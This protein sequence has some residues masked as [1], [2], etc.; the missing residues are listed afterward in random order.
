MT[1]M[2]SIFLAA[3]GLLM[4]VGLT[5]QTLDDAIRLSTL[6]HIGTA[7]FMG[8]GGAMTALG[9]DYSASAYNPAG[10]GLIRRSELTFTPL[11][12]TNNTD[13]RWAANR[14]NDRFS[15]LQFSNFGLVISGQPRNSGTFTN[16]SF[17]VGYNRLA[18]FHSHIFSSTR[19]EG[20]ILDRFTELGRGL[21]P[22]RIDDFEVGPAYDVFALIFDPTDNTYSSDLEAGTALRKEHTFRTE[23]SI[24]EIY[25]SFAG[26]L[27][28]K[29]IMGLTL[30][31]PIVNI[32]ED[33]IYFEE[34]D[35]GVNP[36]F[37]SFEFTEN[38]ELSGV[39][40]QL[41]AGMIYRHSQALRFG[42]AIHSPTWYSM[43]SEFT[44][45]ATYDY[46]V[47]QI[48]E[49]IPPGPQTANSPRGLFDYN[50]TAPWRIMSGVGYLIQNRGFISFDIEYLDYTS[51]RFNFE[52]RFSSDERVR[53]NE[54]GNELGS[55]LNFRLGGEL[56]LDL[57]RVRGGL[58]F[59]ESPFESVDDRDLIWS[60]GVGIRESDFFLDLAYQRGLREGA[61]NPYQVPGA[62]VQQRVLTDATVSRIALTAGFKF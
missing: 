57:F 42:L 15:N 59:I 34:D 38:D 47:T 8:A 45:S 58:Q 62:E 32:T 40:F 6:D 5:A 16:L 50:F 18:N 1:T 25:L 28:E 11:L 48:E 19:N 24:N 49:G 10:L 33:K 9:A 55:A 35:E 3:F 56:A 46:D 12:Y 2:R 17:A 43:S 23:G 53:N 4:S 7:R 61:Y 41:K 31:V 54:I 44:T 36:V 29:L 30:S 52:S 21:E 22:E 20:S 51:G 60:L 14:E 13:A 26:N 39:G 37:R 27:R